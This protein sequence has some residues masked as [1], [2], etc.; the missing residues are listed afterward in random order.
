[1]KLY[2]MLSAYCLASADFPIPGEERTIGTRFALW[3]RAKML[4]SWL[5]LMVVLLVTVFVVLIFVLFCV[6]YVTGL[7]L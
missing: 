7:S 2:P 1:M 3:Q 6:V 4:G 5:G